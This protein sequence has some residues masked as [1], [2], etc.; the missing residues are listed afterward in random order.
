M[1]M[2]IDGQRERDVMTILKDWRMNVEGGKA[3]VMKNGERE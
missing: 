2:S 1:D 3:T